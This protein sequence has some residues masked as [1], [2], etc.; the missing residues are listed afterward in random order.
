M[1][2]NLRD[3]WTGMLDAYRAQRSVE[4]D[5]P[6]DLQIASLGHADRRQDLLDHPSVELSNRT[7]A[8]QRL[9]N[10]ERQPRTPLL[11]IRQPWPRLRR[12]ARPDRTQPYA[13]M[14]RLCNLGSILFVINEVEQG[15]IRLGRRWPCPSQ[16][17]R[18]AFSE[19][20]DVRRTGS[21]GDR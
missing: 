11:R 12:P 17:R 5:P 19:P 18:S 21:C 6:S 3:I 13:S 14:L 20:V 10:G 15:L 16:A 8:Q 4:G 1:S 7:L 9:D 2:G